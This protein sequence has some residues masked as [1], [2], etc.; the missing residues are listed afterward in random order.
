MG[1][2]LSKSLQPGSL[3]PKQESRKGVGRRMCNTYSAKANA[4][5]DVNWRWDRLLAKGSQRIR[6]LSISTRRYGAKAAASAVA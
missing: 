2:V 5:V 1:E 6:S 4:S 3:I